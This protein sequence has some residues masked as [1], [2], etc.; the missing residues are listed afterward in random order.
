MTAGS[1][2][3]HALL[4]ASAFAAITFAAPAHADDSLQTGSAPSVPIDQSVRVFVA[5]DDLAATLA[6]VVA[7]SDPIGTSAALPENEATSQSAAQV[8]ESAVNRALQDAPVAGD[9]QGPEALPT[10]AE[11]IS[12]SPVAA[13]SASDDVRRE[14]V[15]LPA[16]SAP[17]GQYHAVATQYQPPAERSAPVDRVQRPD[18]DVPVPSAPTDPTEDPNARTTSGGSNYGS[19]CLDLTADGAPICSGDDQHNTDWNCDW[20]AFCGPDIPTVQPTPATP[21]CEIPSVEAGQYQQAGEQYQVDPTCEPATIDASDVGQDAAPAAGVVPAAGAVP[22][23]PTE[24]ESGD[25]G[26]G[27]PPAAA[28]AGTTAVPPAEQVPTTPSAP[29]PHAT[30]DS[31]S[32]QPLVTATTGPSADEATW[33]QE[34]ASPASPQPAPSSDSSRSRL[35]PVARLETTR[36]SKA[37]LAGKSSSETGVRHR[38]EDRIALAPPIASFS[39]APGSATRGSDLGLAWLVLFALLLA[40][41]TAIGLSAAGPLR[42]WAPVWVFGLSARLRSKGLSRSADSSPGASEDGSPIRYRE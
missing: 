6:P 28:D 13:A 4:L 12:P 18:D 26:G 36:S 40:A 34:G 10:Q 39:K 22:S 24:P 1:R 30:A 23:I 37:H 38:N 31:R 32:T 27:A 11:A 42:L 41:G 14:L 19:N 15:V 33:S 8:V 29:R 5:D 3:R 17:P 2:F 35:R 7:A 9:A 16:R 25:C 21:G 20:I